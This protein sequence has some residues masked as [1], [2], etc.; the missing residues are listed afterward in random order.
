MHASLAPIGLAVALALPTVV[1]A[2]PTVDVWVDPGH[3]AHDIGTPGFD[4]V[5]VEKNIALQVSAHVF[6]RIS[7]LG[8]SVYLTRLSD[9]FVPLEDRARM[10][11]GELANVNG[12]LGI[13]QL[14]ISM[15]MDGR[16]DQSKFG[17]TTYYQK[18]M[19][20]N[21][22]KNASLVGK[23]M[24]DI[25]HPR[26]ISNT[27]AAFLGCNKDLKVRPANY[28]VLR[29]SAVPSILVESCILT[30]QCQQN[31]IAQNGNQALV[32]SG[33][34]P[35]SRSRSPQAAC[36]RPSAG[37]TRTHPVDRGSPR[38]SAARASGRTPSSGRCRSRRGLRTRPS[39]RP[40]GR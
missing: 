16:E 5:R 23:G 37:P 24:A 6:A 29:N 18:T 11:S 20:R 35:G 10:A 4:S 26:L 27:A 40:A 13:C 17:T 15:H 32:A 3:G 34:A 12:D 36:R 25:I 14:F 19:D 9:Y 8:Y 33:I 39:R 7:D 1:S 21:R 28:S 22:R 38:W 30:N 31:R 2:Q